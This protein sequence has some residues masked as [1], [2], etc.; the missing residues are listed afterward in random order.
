MLQLGIMTEMEID[1]CLVGQASSLSVFSGVRPSP[2]AAPLESDLA[3][4]PSNAVDRAELDV[5]EDG[6]TPLNRNSILPSGLPAPDPSLHLTS[7]TS[8]ATQKRA[9]RL[10]NTRDLTP[11]ASRLTDSRW[12][13][14]ERLPMLRAVYPGAELEPAIV[15]PESDE[16]RVWEHEEAV[17]EL[18]RGRMEVAG[19]ITAAALAEI[20][21]LSMTEIDAG[22]LALEAEGFVLRGKF[23]PD[24]PD[25]EWCDRRLLAR[26]HRLTLNRLRAEIQPVTLAEFQRFLLAWQRVDAEHRAEG[27]EGVEA[28]LDLLDGCELPAAAWEPAVLASRVKDYAP[29]WLDRLCLTGLI[30]WGRLSA[31]QNQKAEVRPHFSPSRNCP[32]GLNF[33]ATPPRLSLLRIPNWF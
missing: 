29:Q 32:P 25:L 10:A 18:V 27:P 21:E 4:E 5:A 6:H 12:V 23:H 8:L 33:H 26:I 19:P 7:L 16:K 24:A 28:V 14:A 2:G 22:L 1:R 15:P 3:I 9:G 11:D 17:R 30:G 31:P 13:A 20:L